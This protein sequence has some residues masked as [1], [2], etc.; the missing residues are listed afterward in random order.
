MSKTEIPKKGTGSVEEGTPQT[1]TDTKAQADVLAKPAE[2]AETTND[3]AKGNEAGKAVFSAGDEG[4]STFKNKEDAEKS[5]KETQRYVDQLQHKVKELEATPPAPQVVPL[6][7]GREVEVLKARLRMNEVFE[8]FATEHPDFKG[9]MRSVAREIIETS[10]EAGKSIKM[11][12]AYHMAKGKLAGL[13]E[14]EAETQLEQEVNAARIGASGSSVRYAKDDSYQPS[15]KDNEILSSLPSLG[16][17]G[18]KNV[19]ERMKK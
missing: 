7:N 18:R 11:V 12:E 16:E 6:Q 10:I 15:E 2:G 1:S 8:D 17:E 13:G 4:S 5:L 9:N 3:S 14:V 19:L